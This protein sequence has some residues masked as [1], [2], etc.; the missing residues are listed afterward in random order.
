MPENEQPQNPPPPGAPPAAPGESTAKVNAILSQVG[1]SAETLAQALAPYLKMP[2]ITQEQLTASMQQALINLH[3]P[4]QLK[5]QV[6][7]MVDQEGGKVASLLTEQ[8]GAAPQPGQLDPNNPLLK[9]LMK[10]AGVDPPA[11]GIG[12][13]GAFSQMAEVVKSIKDVEAVFVEGYRKSWGDG[14][15]D[16]LQVT[17]TVYKNGGDPSTVKPPPEVDVN[18]ITERAQKRVGNG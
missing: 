8:N 10:L 2:V 3:V 4:E 17:S 13:L 16:A 1:L 9:L 15:K 12:G 5:A 18:A 7:S 14:F 11:G 6:K